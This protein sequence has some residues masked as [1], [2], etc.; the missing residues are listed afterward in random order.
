[1]KKKARHQP[2]DG[3]IMV[4][5]TILLRMM[6]MTIMTMTMITMTMITTMTMPVEEVLVV[7]LIK[8]NHLEDKHQTEVWYPINHQQ[9]QQIIIITRGKIVVPVSVKVFSVSVLI[10]VLFVVEQLMQVVVLS[11]TL[12]QQ[13][14]QQQMIVFLVSV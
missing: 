8:L 9:Q 3:M 10:G 6:A 13:Q 12:A 4:P 11:L 7:S 1:M 5:S 2:G 14:Q